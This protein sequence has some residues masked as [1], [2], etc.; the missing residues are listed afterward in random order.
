SSSPAPLRIRPFS[1]FKQ[2]RCVTILGHGR[3]PKI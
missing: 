2:H 3:F 1:G